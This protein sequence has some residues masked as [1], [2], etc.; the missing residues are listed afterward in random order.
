MLPS[1]SKE[2]QTRESWGVFEFAA[3]TAICQQHLTVHKIFIQQ[4][5]KNTGHFYKIH[6]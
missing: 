2:N 4:N 5:A 6:E 3:L 1:N